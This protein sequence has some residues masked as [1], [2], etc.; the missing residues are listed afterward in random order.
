MRRRRLLTGWKLY[1]L[2]GG[3]FYAVLLCLLWEKWIVRH[4]GRSFFYGL[5]EAA[6]FTAIATVCLLASLAFDQRRRGK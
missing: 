3:S 2:V 1:V 4:P 6:V 5:P